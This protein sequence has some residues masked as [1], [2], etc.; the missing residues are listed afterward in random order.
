MS[1]RTLPVRVPALHPPGLDPRRW[2][3][4]V[5]LSLAQFMVILDVTVVNVALPTIAA[6]LHLDRSWL[7]WVV[8]AGVTI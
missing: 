5:L 6:D 7:T 4:L 3:A 1:D 8:A 2:W